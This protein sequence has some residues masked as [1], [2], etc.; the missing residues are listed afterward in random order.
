MLVFSFS[1]V[2]NRHLL[3]GRE[4]I[5]YAWITLISNNT[6]LNFTQYWLRISHYDCSCDI[7]GWHMI[8]KPQLLWQ[9]CSHTWIIIPRC[10]IL[11]NN[12]PPIYSSWIAPTCLFPWCSE[13][14]VYTTST[15]SASDILNPFKPLV[16]ILKWYHLPV[17]SF[18]CFIYGFH[19]K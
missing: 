7:H 6:N 5:V 16:Y 8:S 11:L 1:V 15:I 2:K 12:Y 18:A 13:P 19:R 9:L 3:C 10:S 14:S 17:V 4:I